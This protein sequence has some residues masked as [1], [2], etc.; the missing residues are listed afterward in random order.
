M[1][2][3]SILPKE[4]RYTAFLASATSAFVLLISLL[5]MIQIQQEINGFWGEVDA[6]VRQFRESI[7][8]NWNDL[9]RVRREVYEP[10]APEAKPP[11][12]STSTNAACNCATG[13]SNK[14]P[15]GIPG[16]KGV[17]GRPGNDGKDGLNGI[18]GKDASDVQLAPEFERCYYCPTGQQGTVGPTGKSGPRGMKGVNGK[19]GVA[20]RDGQPGSPGDNGPPGAQGV[21]GQPGPIGEKGR[22]FHQQIGR[23]GSKGPKGPPGPQGPMGNPGIPA[24]PGP[25]GEVRG[26]RGNPGPPGEV[27]KPGPTGF[28]GNNG[29]P[30]PDAHYCSCPPPSFTSRTKA[31]GSVGRGPYNYYF[32]KSRRTRV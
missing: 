25:P 15:P 14:C 18:P 12:I 17:R 4:I 22:D 13:S 27:G 26:E 3:T 30:G 32:G 16:P 5:A 31:T 9:R 20:G 7:D 21:V 28:E 11:G 19:P 8:E 2:T 23:P 29:K 6:G 10:S 24:P 1:S